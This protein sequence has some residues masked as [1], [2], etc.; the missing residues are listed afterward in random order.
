M[1][2]Y[3]LTFPQKN[4]WLVENFYESKLINI[5]SGSLIIKKDFDI[6]KAEQTI[7][8]FVELNEGMRIRI[9]IENSIPKQYVVP[10][11]CF[12]ADKI[13]VENRTEQEIDYIKQEYI[14]TGFDVI[15]SP[16]F[17]Y[18]LID[19]GQGV[20]EIF[21][22]AHHLICDGWAGSKMV[23]GL[24][25]IYDK[26]LEGNKEFQK[27]PSYI[28]YIYK[29]NEYKLSDKFKADE[30]FWNEYLAGF[31]ET[32]GMKNIYLDNCKAKRYSV[33]LSKELNE[34][35]LDYC[36][37]NKFSPYTIF[38]TA[39]AVYLERTT[40]K[41]DIVIGT[42]ILNRGNFAEKQMQGM[43]VSTMPVRFKIDESK[44]FKEICAL[45]AKETLS[46]FRHQ[47]FPISKTIDNL[48]KNNRLEE[49]LYKIMVSYQNARATFSKPDTYRM[50]WNF[51]GYIQD[52]M[53]IHIVDLN[54]DGILEIDYDYIASLFE[55]REI[56]FIS[57]RIE[58]IIEDGI[59]SNS[60]IEEISIMSDEEARIIT[61]VNQTI[62]DYPKQET[63]ISLFEKQ[64]KNN[65]AKTALVYNKDRIS[66]GQLNDRA[67]IFASNLKRMGIKAHDSVGIM[68]D[69]S[70]DLIVCI[71]AI[72]KCGA[73][74][75]P[76]DLNADNL[77]INYIINNSDLK[78][79]ISE[80][81]KE[82]IGNLRVIGTKD[83]KDNCDNEFKTY[84]GDSNDTINIMYTSG[85][86][87]M[88]KG[89]QITNRNIVKLVKNSNYLQF[90]KN[91]NM[92]QTGAFTFDASTLELWNG[93][94]NGITLYIVKDELLDPQSFER[95]IRENKITVIFLTTAIF[96]RMISFN[97]KM[98][99]KTRIIMTG[100]EAI[101]KEHA[102]K[103]LSC[104]KNTVLKNLYGPT[105]NAVVTTF[106]D[107]DI[108]DKVI[109]IGKP[110][111]NTTCYILDGKLRLLPLYVEGNL[112]VGGDGV[113]NGY[114]GNEELTNKKFIES[115][116]YKSKLYDT[117]DRTLLR[118]DGN[119]I[120]L[121]RVDD[122]VKLKGVRVNLDEIRE[123]VN[124][125]GAI[126]N[127]EIICIKDNNGNK[128]L[129]LA[130]VSD[131]EENIE[132]IRLYLKKFLPNYI[133]PRKIIQI[134]NIPLTV[135]GKT[136]K[137]ELELIFNSIKIGSE[138]IQNYYGI[139]LE[140]YNLFKE[141]LEI[142]NIKYDDDFFNIGGD[143]VLGI[144][145]I[146]KA[147]ERKISLTYSDLY[148][149]RTIKEIGD[150]LNSG[151]DEKNISRN[152]KDYDY[153]DIEELLHEQ[154]T[155]KYSECKDIILSGATGYLGMHIIAEFIES[156]KGKIYCLV[157]S[158]DGQSSIERFK[159]RLAYYFGNKY[160]N[161]IG[162]R[163]IVIEYTGELQK[164][165]DIP[166][167][168]VTHFINSL[169]LVK[170]YGNF[171]EFY[172]VNVENVELISKFCKDNNIE[173]VQIST[174]SVSGDIVET[175]QNLESQNIDKKIYTEKDFYNGQQLDNIY[176]YTKFIAER[177][178]YEK[179]IKE[180]LRARIL[181][182]GNLSDRLA[183]GK[184]QIN[185][186]ENAFSARLKS[187]ISI[188][189]I[190]ENTRNQYIDF[191]PIDFAAKSV[192]TI[193][194]IYEPQ[195]IYHLYNNNK[196]CI[197]TIVEAINDYDIKIKF[198]TD[199]E[200]RNAIYNMVEED[201]QN[202]IDGII[203]DINKDAQL[204]YVT[205]V[206]VTN[207]ISTK[208]LNKHEF[209]WPKITNNY[210]NK[211]IERIIKS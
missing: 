53:E 13:N 195:L 88:P 27:Y 109:P 1:D 35:I 127:S 126:Q 11:S 17:S 18:L 121:G 164:F 179:I 178:V 170:H 77:R 172:R 84:L 107:V 140:L 41:S 138:D 98:F 15:D 57:K 75:V 103:L 189:I 31:N 23:T 14:S 62:T 97:A 55:D 66:Y 33:K 21:L 4:I 28:D 185:E 104:C 47:R 20:G 90:N 87:G 200:V 153:R 136:D 34:L 30:V 129:A 101:S 7:N 150:M 51:S 76:I 123:K 151:K 93:L 111:S 100:G 71:L 56:E 194:D 114:I 191:T 12:K 64:S 68:M 165:E 168:N 199:D 148:K 6:L 70:I 166:T 58:A 204:K 63:V 206:Q 5:I 181:R 10:F 106:Y 24:A 80:H 69:K 159:Q 108:E 95:Y 48:K 146:T 149:Y 61:D 83:I 211:V 171:E 124:K 72:L 40:E 81:S 196:V 143:S 85:T 137:K 190:P 176:A 89:V 184:F 205:D 36:R 210:L 173:L 174:L 152:I 130:F 209:V 8:K 74:Y 59:R 188:G 16:L 3:E 156:K 82:N 128:Y 99:N 29:E 78:L 201:S 163:I 50:S 207:D 202:K 67:S 46:L 96:N 161:Q 22:K 132:N 116:I 44:T 110:I 182:M 193:L 115:N 86:T 131:R 52:E 9:C 91:D 144:T 125:Y 102:L 60:T 175:A 117:G 39:L 65:F 26:I 142:E 2:K 177:K 167:S 105:E 45:S 32:V 112:F 135:N 208:I 94:L 38:I 113:A 169:A 180:N 118:E 54:D 122:E 187:L 43:F 192:V 183:D 162:T 79:I 154:Y 186:K 92:L 37:E 145:L 25:E 134:Q 160:D 198:G 155:L 147:L 120:F 203:V 133:I 119:I 139:Y 197:E 73:V 49:S 19:R 157:R 42:P 158:I 141:V